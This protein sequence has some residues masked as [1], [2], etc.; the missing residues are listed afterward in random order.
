MGDIYTKR[1]KYVNNGVVIYEWEQSI[2][3][4]NIFINM[5]SRVVSKKDLDIDLRSKRIRIGLK[6]ME[7]FLEGELFGLIDEGCSYWFIEDNNLHILLTKVRKA[8]TWS[9]V[10]KG[11]KCINAI[12]EDNTRKKIL[13]ERF[14]NEYPTFDFSSAA[15]NGQVPDARTFMGGVKY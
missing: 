14:Q 4:I 10:F 15:F 1:H 13:L 12:D 9:S 2:D 7:S 3:E 8:E 5:N 11:H 6:G